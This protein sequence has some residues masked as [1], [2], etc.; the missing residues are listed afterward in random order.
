MIAKIDEEKNI[1]YCLEELRLLIEKPCKHAALT[2]RLT[3]IKEK[4]DELYFIHLS[5]RHLVVFFFQD[6]QE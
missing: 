2:E 4:L 1:M 6:N 5:L 3:T